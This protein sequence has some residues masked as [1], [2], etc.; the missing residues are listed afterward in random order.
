MAK[1]RNARRKASIGPVEK[2]DGP[3]PEQIAKGGYVR[4]D[5][6]HGETAKGVSPHINRGGT[7]V[8]RWI[9][10]G[11]LSDTQQRAIAHCLYLWRSSLFR[12]GSGERSGRPNQSQS[13]TITALIHSAQRDDHMTDTTHDKIMNLIAIEAERAYR[14]G[15]QQGKTL[16]PN[17][18]DTAIAKWR[19][20]TSLAD[21]VCPD[22]GRA[23]ACCKTPRDRLEI[24]SPNIAARVDQAVIN[25]ILSRR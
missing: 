10:D 4:E 24:E 25:H 17:C 23:I 21:A 7:P 3:T 19:F 11:K 1:A 6:I 2:L 5:F 16:G 13:N 8:M 15:F 22:T 18:D 14:R 20:K 9:D 12:V